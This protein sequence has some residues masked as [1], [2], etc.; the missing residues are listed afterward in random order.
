MATSASGMTSRQMAHVRFDAARGGGS[1]VSSILSATPGDPGDHLGDGVVASPRVRGVWRDSRRGRARPFSEKARGAVDAS[2]IAG[3]AVALVVRPRAT[4][5]TVS[6]LPRETASARACRCRPASTPVGA[7]MRLCDVDV[8]ARA[9]AVA[10]GLHGRARDGCAPRR[11][12]QR[13]TS[14][15]RRGGSFQRQSNR[16]SIRPTAIA[17]RILPTRFETPAMS[18]RRRS[19][20]RSSVPSHRFPASHR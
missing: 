15:W 13:L 2:R 10:S 19:G 14:N 16:R 12:G 18:D 5:R 17:G 3:C 4:Q 11:G 9:R 7:V 6:P 1:G 20:R 8:R